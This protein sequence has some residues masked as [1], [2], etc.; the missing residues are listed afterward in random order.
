MPDVCVVWGSE[1]YLRPLSGAQLS[2][3]VK[4]AG[5]EV[6]AGDEML[7]LGLGP[8]LGVK[9]GGWG[10]GGRLTAPLQ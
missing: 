9:P 4:G 3:H 7:E 1:I 10:P 5:A 8:G 6:W 2:N